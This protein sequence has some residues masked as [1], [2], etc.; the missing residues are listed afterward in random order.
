MDSTAEARFG[1]YHLPGDSL[2]FY[3]QSFGNKCIA[4]S[5]EQ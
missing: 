5:V 2:Y 3:F 1:T 4:M